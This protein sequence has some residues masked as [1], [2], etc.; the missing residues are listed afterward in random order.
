MPHDEHEL[1][2]EMLAG[3]HDAGELDGA[4]D[5]AGRAHDEQVAQPHHEH[6]LGDGARIRAGDDPLQA[7]ERLLGRQHG[8]LLH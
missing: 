4:H 6:V 2:A 3:V 1:D 8:N 7:L 5:V